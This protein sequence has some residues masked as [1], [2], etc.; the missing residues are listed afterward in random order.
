MMRRQ[1]RLLTLTAAV[2]ACHAVLPPPGAAQLVTRSATVDTVAVRNAAV[3]SIVLGA[4]TSRRIAGAA[5]TIVQHGVTVKNT[6]YGLANTATGERVTPSTAF[7]V[8]SITKAITAALALRLV[9]QGLVQ[10]D[11][12][13]GR[14]LTEFPAQWHDVTIRH[15]LDMTSGLPP[16]PEA[17]STYDPDYRTAFDSIMTRPVLGKPGEAQHYDR[18]NYMIL[19]RVIEAMTGHPFAEAA[20]RLIFRPLELR[21]AAMGDWRAIRPGRAEWYSTYIPP[22]QFT[23]EPYLLRTDYPLPY[24]PNAGLFIS[25]AD[26]A[27]FVDALDRGRLLTPATRAA[28]FRPVQLTSGERASLWPGAWV[29]DD[30][31]DGVVHAP[32]VLYHE[33]GVRAAVFYRRDPALIIVILTNTQGALPTQWIGD[34]AALYDRR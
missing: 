28:L 20:E 13:V 30:D 12:P 15:L 11:H 14:Y 17:S 22:D 7:F 4:M 18:T 26:L 33:G 34:I 3:D 27:A 1:R 23:A 25:A 31:P 10:L 32:R 9:D 19:G 8:A 6:A 21:S 24:R 29:P 16:A 5:V 2:A